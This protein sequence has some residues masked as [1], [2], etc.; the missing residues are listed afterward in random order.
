MREGQ[1]EREEGG[2]EI[3][4]EEKLRARERGRRTDRERKRREKQ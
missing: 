3:R 1:R 4:R 2:K